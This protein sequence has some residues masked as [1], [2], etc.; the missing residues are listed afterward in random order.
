MVWLFSSGKGDQV[1]VTKGL[2]RTYPNSI[3]RSSLFTNKRLILALFG[4]VVA[5]MFAIYWE[6]MQAVFKTA[7]IMKW[8]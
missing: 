5:M 7:E 2:C 1:E 8:C 6:P 4:S 3:F